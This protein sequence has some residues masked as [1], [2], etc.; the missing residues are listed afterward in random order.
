MAQKTPQKTPKALQ[1]G[2]WRAK[3]RAGEITRM[4]LRHL[5]A[6]WSTRCCQEAVSERFWDPI[7]WSF[8][9]PVWVQKFSPKTDTF[10]TSFWAPFWGPK[11]GPGRP[12][13]LPR[14][15]SSAQKSAKMNSKS[16][17]HGS[18]GAPLKPYKN[19]VFY[20]ALGPPSCP[21]ATR[22]TPKRPRVATLIPQEATKRTA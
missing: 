20:D 3:L 6:S 11:W 10:L 9:G 4:Q 22:E 12:R 8:W 5:G 18:F 17:L 7:L 13:K 21:R 15:P 1:R 19:T 14:W 16:L 2:P